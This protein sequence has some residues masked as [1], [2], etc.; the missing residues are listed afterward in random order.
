MKKLFSLLI[1]LLL[2][3]SA[4]AANLL[5]KTEDTSPTSDDMMYVVNDPASTQTDRKVTL[6][7]AAKAMTSTNLIDTADLLYETELDVEAEL[8][9]QLT[10]VTNLITEAEIDT[11]AELNAILTDVTLS[12]DTNLTEEEVEDF[13]GSMVETT[14]TET[15]ITVTYQDVTNDIDF[16]VDSDLANYSWTN[17]DATDLKTGSVT[18]AYDADLD[19]L[20]DGSLTGTKVGFADTDSNFTATNVQAAI[21]ELDDVNGSGPN[22]A[23]GKVDWSQLV[24]MPAGFA[25][26]TDDGAGGGGA[27]EWTDAGT[28]IF[29]TE[30]NDNVG[31]GTNTVSAMLEIAE[32]GVTPFMISNSDGAGN[33]DFFIVQSD[34]FVGIGTA[35]P[36]VA[37]ELKGATR[38]TSSQSCGTLIT[39]AD[40]DVSCGVG[41]TTDN[42]IARYDGTTGLLQNSSVT[43]DDTGK[44]TAA[45]FEISGAAA[46]SITLQELP[47]NGSETVTLSA[48]DSIA[49]SVDFELPA[50][51]GTSGQALVTNGSAV[52]SFA[53]ISGGSGAFSDAAD[54]VVLNTTTKDVV[55]GT[56]AV[57]T[58]KLTIDGDADQVQLTVQGNATQT[59]S[60]VIVESSAGTEVVNIDV[61]G[62]ILTAVGLDAIGAVDMDYGSA[63]VTDHTFITDGTG[64]AE[65]VLP[66]GSIDST[67]ILDATIAAADIGADAVGESELDESMDFV[68]AG[69]WDFSAGTVELPNGTSPTLLNTGE[70]AVDT[71][72]DQYVFKGSSSDRVLSPFRSFVMGIETPADA[73]SFLIF[74]AKDAITVTDIHCIVD[75]ADTSES[76]VID[77]QE[78]NSTGDSCT[79]LDATITCDNDG[80]EDD[81]TLTNPTIDAGDW[82]LLDV[83]TVTGTVT[84]VDVTAYY[85]TDRE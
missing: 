4:Y 10:D 52:L 23:D 71:T 40:G 49:T 1:I 59:D 30:I 12:A 24:N 62:K 32:D 63:D 65:I 38:L 43:I 45:E 7:N 26:G 57:N 77:V 78:C 41:T 37:I 3:T 67:E 69:A 11:L 42:A 72:D 29:P 31:I 20:A 53:T 13:A 8:E 66:A 36:Q 75:P 35:H 39:D 83:G 82:V 84:Q 61:D 85:T 56:G 14:N 25:D 16:V 44:V 33:G 9:A 46:G 28:Y 54:P 79:T 18:Q 27:S 50:A 19:D 34:G 81:G 5:D 17:V 60:V 64:T 68:A 15:L 80:A 74:K 58:S 51:D 6:G 76:V 48:P 73:D 22:A 47:A 2:A 70:A 21:E 55:V